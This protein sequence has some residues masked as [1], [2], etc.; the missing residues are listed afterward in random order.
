MVNTIGLSAAADSCGKVLVPSNTLSE[1]TE[2]DSLIKTDSAAYSAQDFKLAILNKSNEL[3]GSTGYI[4]ASL[5]HQNGESC[6]LASG[7][8]YGVKY[9]SNSGAKAFFDIRS[10]DANS[11][12]GSLNLSLQRIKLCCG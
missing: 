11:L 2:F 9:L 8:S 1:Q 10:V 7:Q 5:I 3:F 4:Y 6:A 12:N